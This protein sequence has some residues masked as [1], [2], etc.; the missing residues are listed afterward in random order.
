MPWLAARR[1]TSV[2]L[3]SASSAVS[4]ASSRR[5]VF[6][7]TSRSPSRTT[8]MLRLNRTGKGPGSPTVPVTKYIP[9]RTSRSSPWGS[10]G[11]KGRGWVGIAGDSP[12]VSP[13]KASAGYRPRWA[14]Q[15]CPSCRG[16]TAS[17]RAATVRAHGR[18]DSLGETQ[19]DLG[20]RPPRPGYRAVAVPA[21]RHGAVRRGLGLLGRV[22]RCVPGDHDLPGE[23]GSRPLGTAN[24]G[25]AGCREG[26]DPEDHSE[27]R[28]R[29]LRLDD[30]RA[31][32][33][34]SIRLV[35]YAAAGR[36]RR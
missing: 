23:V 8:V 22:L 2:T 35:A 20:P 11:G 27:R 28:Q 15:A 13:S 18:R 6:T 36:H 25:G 4:P 24:A 21:R 33:R 3:P 7:K 32:A 34:P 9:G 31:G 30:P 26:V 1:I 19:G 10:A 12:W 16:A 29:R 17:R 5:T 14:G